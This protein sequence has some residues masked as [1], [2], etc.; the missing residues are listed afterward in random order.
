MRI[1]ITNDDGVQAP[2][3]NV[4]A[5]AVA[6]AGHDVIVVAPSGERSGS[7]A[8]MGTV[9]HGTEI[10]VQHYDLGNGIPAYSVEGPPALCSLLGFFEVF[11]PVP[12]L[13]LAGVNPGANTGRGLL[14]SGTVGAILTAADLGISGIAVSQQYPEA[15]VEQ[16][17]ATAA[18]VVVSLLPWLVQQPRKTALNVN[19]PNALHGELRGFRWGRIA[20]FGPTKMRMVGPVPGVVQTLVTPREVE[21]RPDTDTALVAAGFVSITS[22]VTPRATEPFDPAHLFDAHRDRLI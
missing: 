1:L 12:D 9:G 3:I 4:L 15:G 14:Q 21:L 20:A 6:A 17:F 11:G 5:A 13:V 22:V 10:D 7:G 8:A 2:G 19:V 18:E 16:R